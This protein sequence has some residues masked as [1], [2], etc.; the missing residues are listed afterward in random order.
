MQWTCS[1]ARA[2]SL[3][4]PIDVRDQVC[5]RQNEICG[6]FGI[7]WSEDPLATGLILAINN[8]VKQ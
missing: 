7:R 1:I 8:M 4:C 5:K 3:S 2:E 6:P